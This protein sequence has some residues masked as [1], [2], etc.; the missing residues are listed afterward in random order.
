MKHIV[1]SSMLI[2]L[3]L[4]SCRN[5]KT[6]VMQSSSITAEMAY[7]GVNNYCHSEYDWS[8]AE[9]NPSMMS[10]T[11]GEETETEY[12]VIFR[13][14]TGALVT[15]HVD[16]ANGKTRMVEFVPT[17]DEESEAGTINIADYLDKDW[18]EKE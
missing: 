6:D 17:L 12:Q 9:E 14:Y 10:V 4:C 18:Q 13:S 7:E 15:F 3:M 2:V 8:V 16:K 1:I 5:N 11:M